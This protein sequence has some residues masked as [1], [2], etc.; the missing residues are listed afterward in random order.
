MEERRTADGRLI[1]RDDPAPYWKADRFTGLGA[2]KEDEGAPQ[3]GVVYP[4]GPRSGAE[5]WAKARVVKTQV[6]VMCMC[7]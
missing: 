3:E 1:V 5:L 2:S 4:K 7:L 6:C